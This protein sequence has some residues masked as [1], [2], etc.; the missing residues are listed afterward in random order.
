M[1]FDFDLFVIGA[2]SGGVRAARFAASYG[3]KVA[4]AESNDLGGTCV[5]VG[6][7]PKKLLVYAAQ[8]SGEFAQAEGYG[9][10]VADTDFSWEQLIKNKNSEIRRLNEVYKNLLQ[11]SGVT[12]YK[13]KV[14]ISGVNEVK[15]NNRSIT[16]RHILIATGCA[17][18]V[19]YF[20]G[21][22]HVITSNEVF[23]LKRLPEMIAIVG[24]GYIATEFASIFN[25]LGSETSLIYRGD[26]FANGFDDGLRKHLRDE[27]L[28]KGVNIHFNSNISQIV[29]SQ[30]GIYKLTLDNGQVLNA[31]C[32]LYAT[33]RRPM[34]D[35][36]GLESLGIRQDSRGHILV[37]E[38]YC[39]NIPSI[40]AIG[41]VTGSV[42]L[43]PVALAEGMAVAKR[44]FKPEEYQPV[45]YSLVPT[46]MFSLPNL[47][48]AGLTEQQARAKGFRLKIYE[49]KFRPM[50]LVLT[51]DQEKTLMKLVVDAETDRV[52]GCHMAGPDAAEI[53]QGMAIA[54]KSGVT[55]RILDESIGI[56]PCSAEE[57]V[58][59]RTPVHID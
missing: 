43:T 54:I 49:S 59:M 12:L 23:Y 4:I 41:D 55:K 51:T 40:L 44:L 18:F 10:H 53:V 25:G 20:S 2:G 39:T 33:G 22:E 29:K 3:A 42:Q 14:G 57:F 6:C 21:K 17:P 52:L 50:K 34:T 16:A 27:M 37:D 24:G 26:L 46:A 38:N 47:A 19:P 45:D 11:G 48:M 31:D 32:I 7:V 35:G 8:Y 13:G 1:S 15:L 5:N 58:T 30:D 28:L 56:H 36:L 9:W